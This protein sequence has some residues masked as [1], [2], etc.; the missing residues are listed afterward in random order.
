MSPLS[1]PVQRIA[2][3]PGRAVAWG[4]PWR[5]G[6]VEASAGFRLGGVPVQSWPLATWPDGSLKWSGHAVAGLP[7]GEHRLTVGDTDRPD[8]PVSVT[9]G[10]GLLVVCTGGL[11]WRVPRSGT[12]LIS[13][14][15][16]DGTCVARGAELVSERQARPPADD[17]GD[18]ARESWVG[19]VRQVRVEQSGPVRAVVRIDGV[20][21]PRGSSDRAPAQWLP[22]RVRLYFTA[23]SPDLRLVHTLVWDGDPDRETLGGLGL[24]VGVPLREDAPNRHVR[25]AGP[26]GTNGR[27][28]FLTEAAQGITGLRRD[29]G[30]DARAAQIAGRRVTR[31]SDTVAGLLRFV[32]VWND[33]RLEQ[34]S[35]DGFTMAKRT[36]AGCAWVTI[37][38]GTRAEGFAYL[39]DPSGGVGLGLRDFWQ[40]YPTRVDVAGAGSDT[41]SL[42]MWLWS[43]SAPAM[44]LRGYHDGLGIA[45]TEE[46]LRAMDI[47]YEDHQPGFSDPRGIA[48]THEL[49]L[50][51]YAAT[52]SAEVLADDAASIQDPAVAVPPVDHLHAHRVFGDWAPVDRSTPAAAQLE[53]RLAW[54]VDYYRE[55]REL[56]R[57]YG[58][59]DYGDVMHTYDP[60]RHQWRYDVGGYAWDNSELSPDLF[61]WYQF[62]RTGSPATYR[63]AEAM[64]RHTGEV[65][66]YHLGRFAMLGSRHNVQHW[67][68]SAKQARISSAIYRRVFY[69]LST[70]ERT[71]DLLAELAQVEQA[72][73]HLDPNRKVRGDDYRPNAD[74]VSI[75]LGTDWSALASAWLTAWERVGD[76]VAR[77]RARDRLVATMEGIA[78]LP[79]GFLTGEARMRLDTCRFDSFPDR[80]Q[81]SHLSAVFGLVEICSEL[82]RLTEGTPEE[83]PGFADAWELYCRL[84]LSTP[85]EQKAEVGEELTGI[86]L[87][88]GHSRLSAWAAH[89]RGDAALGRRAWDS[90]FSGTDRLNSNPVQRQQ[91]WEVQSVTGPGVLRPVTEAPWVSTNDAAQFGLAVIENLA[92]IP[93]SLPARPASPRSGQ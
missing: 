16:V 78:R 59:W 71:G 83:V 86:S 65:D 61:V 70:D 17:G 15:H 91:E 73:A 11:E 4:M 21:V 49:H 13:E 76:P 87:V 38:G 93:A 28:G 14:V 82:V 64:T 57:W 47:T 45:G 81:V 62:L 56:R 33:W 66:V 84:Y 26:A 32:P 18:P 10:P 9:E 34:H 8:A 54:L 6:E 67:G 80:I 24:R 52:P 68:C 89:R 27:P 85:E 20:H 58:F 3:A 75:G 74:V 7:D 88:Q 29:A 31:L 12:E 90:F 63:F 69:Y 48:R 39:G 44:D 50:V 77:D 40:G 36:S 42:T 46:E 55:Q 41:G 72:F 43:P 37:P 79:R 51:A 22:F 35:P 1:G 53:D 5:R 92:L 60:D 19:E 30:A 2:G 23:G 25:I